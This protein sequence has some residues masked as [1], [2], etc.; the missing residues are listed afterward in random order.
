LLPRGGSIL[1]IEGPAQ[2]SSAQKRTA[3][4]LETKP[5]NIQISTLLLSPL[6]HS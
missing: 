3:G 4:M 2:S 1:Y 6:F 5:S